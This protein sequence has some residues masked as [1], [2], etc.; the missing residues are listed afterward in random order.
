MLYYYCENEA[1]KEKAVCGIECTC[2]HIHLIY[3]IGNQSDIILQI[4]AT[5]TLLSPRLHLLSHKYFCLKWFV[6]KG[7]KQ[8]IYV[9][10]SKI[11]IYANVDDEGSY[12]FGN[13]PREEN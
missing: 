13:F 1:I 6:Y 11:V 9:L 4:K 10:Y 2:T 3:F 8:C 12:L 7:N 5:L